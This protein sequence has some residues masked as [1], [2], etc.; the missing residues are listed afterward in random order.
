[1]DGKTFIDEYGW[2]EAERVANDAG[3]N[4]AYFSQIANGHRNASLALAERLVA[5]SGGRLDL[6][7]LMKAKALRE[8]R[9]RAA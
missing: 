5:A 2:A 6:M 8:E 4:R 9:T 7:A 1:M 3:T